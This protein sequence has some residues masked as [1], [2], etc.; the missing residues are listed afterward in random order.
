MW[1]YFGLHSDRK[2]LFELRVHLGVVEQREVV[3]RRPSASRSPSPPEALGESTSQS[4][5]TRPT[6]WRGV[7]VARRS[8]RRDEAVPRGRRAAG[9]RGCRAAGRGCRRCGGAG[10]ARTAASPAR[11][12][13]PRSSAWTAWSSG[14]PSC[15][16]PSETCASRAGPVAAAVARAAGDEPAHRVPDERDPLDPTGQSQARRSAP[17]AP[18]R[19][20]RCGG[21]CC[22][23]RAPGSSPSRSP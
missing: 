12:A 1:A 11:G 7:I 22:S 17:P 2:P 13:A 4:P 9:R 8:W 5:N 14:A 6:G 21:R 19:C 3:R 20:R 10:S 23:G 16:V 15:G 18:R